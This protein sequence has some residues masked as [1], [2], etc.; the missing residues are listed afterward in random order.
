[1]GGHCIAVEM[2][3]RGDHLAALQAVDTAR[4]AF[5]ERRKA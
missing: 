5:G 3:G 2:D 4:G 1:M